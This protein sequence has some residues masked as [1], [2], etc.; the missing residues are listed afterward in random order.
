MIEGM[1]LTQLQLHIFLYA[2][3]CKCKFG[4]DEWKCGGQEF[5]YARKILTSMGISPADQEKVLE[6]CEENGGHCD[7][8]ILMNATRFLLGEETI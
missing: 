4:G 7:C 3:E 8:E 1:P 5:P 6:I 2:L